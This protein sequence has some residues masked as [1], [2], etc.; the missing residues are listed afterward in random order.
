LQEKPTITVMN[1]ASPR[2]GNYAFEQQMRANGV[3]VLRV[4]NMGDAV[5]TVPGQREPAEV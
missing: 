2:V 3:K 5:P 4:V 1:F